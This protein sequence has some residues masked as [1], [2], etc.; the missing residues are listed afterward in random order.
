[1]AIF[2]TSVSRDS[3]LP[4]HLGAELNVSRLVFLSHTHT[5]S[6]SLWQDFDHYREYCIHYT[7]AND[8]LQK[9]MNENEKLKMFITVSSNNTGSKRRSVI[10]YKKEGE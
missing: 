5:L 2:S 6:L 1:M 4:T 7:D 9:S 10:P 3:A 8:F